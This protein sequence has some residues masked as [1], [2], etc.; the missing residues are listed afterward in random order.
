VTV[1]QSAPIMIVTN[2]REMSRLIRS[3][4]TELKYTEVT[5]AAD[6]SIALQ[7]LREQSFALILSDWEMAP[8]SGLQFLQQVRADETLKSVR[9]ILL[10]STADKK[11]VEAAKTAGADGFIV[12]PFSA[13]TL[14]HKLAGIIPHG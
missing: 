11:M 9:F 7:K 10:S 2:Y 13:A 8:I 12:K 1:D 5:D 3:V 14:R 4:L 6:V